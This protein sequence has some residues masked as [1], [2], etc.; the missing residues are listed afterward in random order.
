MEASLAPLYSSD[1][2]TS[3]AGPQRA[4]RGHQ[5]ATGGNFKPDLVGLFSFVCE[6]SFLAWNAKG[7]EGSG[8]QERSWLQSLCALVWLIVREAPWFGGIY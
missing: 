5:D 2:K 3:W 6:A 7:V 4:G 1:E 8:F